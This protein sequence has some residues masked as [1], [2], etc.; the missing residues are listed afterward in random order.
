[1]IELVCGQNLV[2]L[3]IKMQEGLNITAFLDH[4]DLCELCF[5][6]QGTLIDQLNKLIGGSESVRNF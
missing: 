6:H 2:Q 1:M 3:G 4:L 5:E